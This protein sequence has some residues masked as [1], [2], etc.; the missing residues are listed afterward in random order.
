MAMG[1]AALVG[2]VLT[3]ARVRLD[4]RLAARL[5]VRSGS[6]VSTLYGIPLPLG[7]GVMRPEGVVLPVDD[8]D[9]AVDM[10][11]L[12]WMR[13]GVG[14]RVLRAPGAGVAVLVFG[15]VKNRSESMSLVC[16]W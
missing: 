13:I 6:L 16:C 4:A 10:P 8:V 5:A 11:G 2:L 15:L 14:M 1:V 7:T 3:P 12:P 9:V